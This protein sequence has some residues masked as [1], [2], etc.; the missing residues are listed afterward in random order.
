MPELASWLKNADANSFATEAKAL[1][2]YLHGKLT[3]TAAATKFIENME[4]V[5]NPSFQGHL[6]AITC[7]VSDSRGQIKIV[8]PLVTIR[9]LRCGM[10]KGRH[11]LTYV[12]F[13]HFIA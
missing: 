1:K 8:N 3:P 5:W 7:D 10:K 2:D 11:D 12:E 6:T 4:P 9:N 13:G